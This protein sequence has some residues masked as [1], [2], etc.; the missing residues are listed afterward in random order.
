VKSTYLACFIHNRVYH[1]KR[2]HWTMMGDE[3]PT[4][5]DFHLEATACDIC[6]GEQHGT[7]TTQEGGEREKPRT[8]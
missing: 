8:K 4:H 5:S 2:L 1:P 6:K 3:L 7:R